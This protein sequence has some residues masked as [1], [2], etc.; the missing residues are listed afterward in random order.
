VNEYGSLLMDGAGDIMKIYTENNIEANSVE[1]LLNYQ[2]LKEMVYSLKK[3]EEEINQFLNRNQ[4]SKDLG[5]THLHLKDCGLI[6]TN[7]KSEIVIYV[8]LNK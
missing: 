5:F 1:V 4:D 3:F 7:S 6:E 2:E 8:N